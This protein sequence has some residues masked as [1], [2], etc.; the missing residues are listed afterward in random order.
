MARPTKLDINSG[1]QGWDGKIDDNDEAIFN[2]PFPIHEHTGDQ[3][4]LE[5]TFPA[6]SYDRCMVWVD[7]TAL[8]WTLYV[9]DGSSWVI[10]DPTR[11][12]YFNL[13]ATTSMAAVHRG[14][15]VRFTSTGTVDFDLEPAANW[16]NQT[17]LVRND[18]SSG[19]L[20]LDPNG[21]EN[22]N[23]VSGGPL[24]VAAGATAMV[25]STGSE[26]FVSFMT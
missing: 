17:V 5:S 12:E 25:Y 24:V 15:F 4:D 8:G 11:K 10:F 6:A 16:R 22:I 9:S 21:S 14:A 1:I 13:T 23:G 3:T 2:A 7:H 18:K 20:N 26:V 19:T